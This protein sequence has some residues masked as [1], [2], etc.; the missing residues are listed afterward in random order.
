[1]PHAC[2]PSQ[3]PGQSEPA[4]RASPPQEPRVLSVHAPLIS[5]DAR[6]LPGSEATPR[7]REGS[8]DPVQRR[9]KESSM[10]IWSCHARPL[11][12]LS[13]LVWAATAPV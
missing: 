2:H 7:V 10:C 11:A 8:R 3:L 5:D 9:R 12:Q 6:L 4:E 13:D 1:M